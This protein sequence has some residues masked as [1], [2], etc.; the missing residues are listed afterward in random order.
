MLI[1]GYF[2]GKSA[3][4]RHHEIRILRKQNEHYYRSY[5]EELDVIEDELVEYV[6]NSSKI[7]NYYNT[8]FSNFEN[9]FKE[10]FT[11]CFL[12]TQE[13]LENE[14]IENFIRKFVKGRPTNFLECK[15]NMNA[16]LKSF[17]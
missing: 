12:K 6:L 13:S 14:G 10:N 4:D 16:F 17:N 15:K 3:S 7:Q 5:D 9:N 11:S 1:L 8:S 2:L